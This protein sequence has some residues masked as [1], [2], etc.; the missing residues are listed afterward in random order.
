[1]ASVDNLQK[2]VEVVNKLTASIG[3]LTAKFTALVEEGKDFSE[4]QKSLGKELDKARA[5]YIKVT[6]AADSMASATLRLKN[7][8]SEQIDSAVELQ[9][10]L[11]TLESSYSTL[12]N[13]TLRQLN[14]AQKQYTDALKAAE[15]QAKEAAGAEKARFQSLAAQAKVALA[16]VKERIAIQKAE[17]DQ[18]LRILKEKVQK[19]NEAEAKITA[20][21][22]GAFKASIERIKTEDREYKKMIK[23]QE[24]L[25]NRLKKQEET[26]IK[27]EQ[28]AAEKLAEKRKFFGKAFFDAFSPQAIGKAIASIVKFIS[29]YEILG[30]VVQQVQ[31]FFVDSINA[32]IDF[33]RDLSRVSAVT[34]ASGKA[35]KNL[36]KSIREIAVETRFTA[37]DVSGLAI[38]LGK[39]G[40]S[41]A[42][43]PRLLSPISIAAQATGEDLTAVGTAIVKVG[44]QFNLSSIEAATTSA[45]LTQAVNESALTL[46]DFGTA[47]G[48]VGPL[49]SQSGLT[50]DKTA[51]ALG[52]LSDNGFSASRAGTGLRKILIELKKPGVDITETL[53]EL[54]DANIGVAKAEE[55]VGKTAA[56]QLITLLRNIDAINEST[57]AQEGFAAQLKATSIQM[58][59]FSG[60][61][62]ILKSAYNE[63][64]I[65]VGEF[66]V[67]NEL[68][69]QAIGLLSQK[70]E[71]LARGF[72]VIK[73][74]S[75]RLG[76]AFE[77]R[78]AQGL[79]EGN[80]ELELLNRLLGDTD[81]KNIKAVLDRLNAA[82][83]KNLQEL[84]AE[85]DKIERGPE[86]VNIFTSALSKLDTRVGLLTKSF[87]NLFYT[88]DD[89]ASGLRGVTSELGKQVAQEKTNRDL[90]AGV[91]AVN[92]EYKSQVDAIIA[93]TSSQNKRSKAIELSQKL[94]SR[95]KLAEEQSNKLLESSNKL[96]VS[97]G[98]ILAGRAKQYRVLAT[99][100]SEYTT[101]LKSSSKVERDATDKYVGLFEQRKKALDLELKQIKD[102]I[103]EERKANKSRE[104]SINE[105]YDLKI[106]AASTDAEVTELAIKKQEEL[107]EAAENYEIALYNYNAALTQWKGK[108]GQFQS[109]FAVLFKGSE[110]NTLRLE[111]A[112]ESLTQSLI[113]LAQK[114]TEL[115]QEAAVTGGDLAKELLSNSSDVLSA[116][117]DGLDALGKSYSD[118]AY[119]QY[120]LY[121]AQQEY[122]DGLDES[123]NKLIAYYDSI[124]DQLSP[125]ELAKLEAA[126]DIVSRM[127]NDAASGVITDENAEKYKKEFF[128]LGAAFGENWNLGIDLTFGEAMNMILSNTLDSISK[129]NDVALENTKNRLEREKEAI[130]NSADIE[131]QILQAK[132]EN[133]LITESEYR[134]QIEKNRRKE[135]QAMNKIEKQ[136]FDAEQKRD[137]QGALT[138]YLTS[139]ASIVPNLIIND[140]NGDP[141][142]ISLKAALTA[143]LSTASYA[144]ELKAIN[145]RKFFPT[146]FAEGGVVQ[147]PSHAEGGIPFSVRG[148]GGYEMEGG[149]YI[150]NKRSTQKYKSLL[151]QINNYGKSN[152]KFA[153]G[154]VVKDPTEVS[155]RQLELLEAIA[156]SNVSMVGKLDKPVRAFVATDDLRT[157]EN[158]RRIQE[159]NSQ[160]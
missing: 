141:I 73:Q 44:N 113:D 45:I 100:L 89:T 70:S 96:E 101:E 72:G 118:T 64:Q 114:L 21:K 2:Q 35:L 121:L 77:Q 126:I 63:I 50:F 112:T 125:E 139:L 61:V 58:S 29:I 38:E 117:K 149:E 92:E 46:E 102:S 9:K 152:Y 130:Q 13:K 91:A 36:E 49:A 5:D 4:I 86:E 137:R 10:K 62:D 56:A 32:F 6:K 99:A 156:M 65:S 66:L 28:I 106:K 19:S 110:K 128:E 42:N 84:N 75:E 52:V 25:F 20:A 108:V 22:K 76:D 59:S 41:A 60:Q 111:N 95:A 15:K 134:A 18:N 14:S 98:N 129:F 157:D 7:A 97:K 26:R 115:N 119:G 82:N 158:A 135:A 34:G 16:E 78:L 33:D 24:R 43:I 90:A 81:D 11:K 136:I 138:D 140:K 155:K 31:K 67:S 68:V 37:N 55:L 103:E 124:K 80:T 147:G 159:R 154:G 17:R 148:Q 39:L 47:I 87:F 146:K 107:A 53:N 1:M 109:E 51:K 27:K 40:V 8:D 104:D 79:K 145:Q 12:G 144:N 93:L 23:E 120:Q 153:A 122:L 71:D 142:T 105:Y 160:L 30:T 57:I 133:Q 123:R 48:Y 94:L 143:A 74:E 54:A 83:P 3:A 116:F 150:V 132:L 85:L 131:D 151:D 69:I 88:I 127:F